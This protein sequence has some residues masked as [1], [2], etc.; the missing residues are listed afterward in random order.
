MTLLYGILPPLMA[1]Q[2]RDKLQAKATK[3]G[4][5][6]AGGAA[7]AAQSLRC[8]P[9][10]AGQARGA[11]PLTARATNQP[12]VP[13]WQL[14]HDEMVPGGQPVLAGMFSAACLIGLSRL[15]ADAGLTGGP[16]NPALQVR[17]AGKANKG[18]LVPWPHAQAGGFAS[19]SGQTAAVAWLARQGF[20]GA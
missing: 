14:Q 8:Q 9:R 1:W 10:P 16:G 7:D 20:A 13:W 17:R 2:L 4:Q 6:A 5:A 11:V 12:A 15:A 18:R 19:V 3:A